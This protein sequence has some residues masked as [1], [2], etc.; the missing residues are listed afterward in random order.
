MD[1]LSAEFFSAL[2]QII[3]INLVLSGD[4]AIVIALAA[5][6]LPAE[7]QKKV[8]IWGTVG[9]VIVRAIATLLVVRL[10]D[11]PFVMLLGGLVLVW[12]SYKLLVDDEDHSNIKAQNTLWASI[13]TIIIADA[14]MGVDNVLAVAGAAGGN[15]L[16][17]IIGLII[18]IPIVVWGSTLFI[19]LINRFPAIIYLGSGVLAWTAAEM[20]THEEMI[21]EYL[22]DKSWLAWTF[23]IAVVIG[24]LLIGKFNSDKKTG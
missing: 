9:A 8:V 21:H 22:A 20:I 1:F 6:N 24:V 3:F 10:L 15:T 13:R 18:G 23:S 16:L 11:L 14:A 19:K 2:L 12:I 17:I 7:Q 4:N 5:R